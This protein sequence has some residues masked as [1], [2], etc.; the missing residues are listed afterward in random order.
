M[1]PVE[2][3][4]SEGRR[5]WAV[6]FAT[7]ELYQASVA[8]Y[9]RLITEV[10]MTV[11]RLRKALERMGAGQNTVI[12]Y[13]SDNG[14]YLGE[15]GL[16]G[17]WLMHEESIRTPLIVHDPRRPAGER[18]LRREEMTLNIDIAPTLLDA[19]GVDAPPQ[20]QGR[21]LYRLLEGKSAGWRQ[22]FFYEHNFN[23]AWIPQTEGVRTER[24]KYTRYITVRP[25]FE[26][27]FDL[28]RD[29]MEERN[30]AREPSHRAKV[31]EMRSKYRAW[32]EKLA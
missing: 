23:H 15:H 25:E 27:L 16:A 30:L 10:D 22:E 21:S 32:R 5:R 11:G 1:L 24:W 20:M 18:G 12:V 3:Q 26:E 17:K 2:V 7:P 8:N 19:A 28:E 31:E 9:Y 14:F 13:S 6:R 4:R 29:P